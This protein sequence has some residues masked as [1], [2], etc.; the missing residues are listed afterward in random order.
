MHCIEETM[1]KMSRRKAVLERPIGLSVVSVSNK[2][3]KLHHIVPT[4]PE[5]CRKVSKAGLVV[6][7]G[8]I[9]V[10]A[11]VFTA[12]KHLDNTTHQHRALLVN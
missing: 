2:I 3:D 7:P 4:K 6:F 5:F 10:D 1:T 12:L 8:A 11:A 9:K